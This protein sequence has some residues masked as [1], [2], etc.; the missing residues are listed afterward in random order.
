MQIRAVG[1]SNTFSGFNFDFFFFDTKTIVFISIILYT[2]IIISLLVG[3]S[4]IEGKPRI[5]FDIFYFMII[6]SVIAPFW[7]FKALINAARSKESS[8]TL[9]ID[10]RD[11]KMAKQ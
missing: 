1:F 10:K 7:I 6:Y 5:S 4:I 2:S 8:W 11:A 3:R 9:E